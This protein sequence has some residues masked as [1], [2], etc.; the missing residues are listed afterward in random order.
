[1]DAWLKTHVAEIGPT[2]GA[3]Y[4]SGGD[5]NRL[6]RTRDAMLLMLRAIREGYQVLG[7]HEIPITPAN[8]RLFEWLPEPLLLGIMKRMIT[9]D[10]AAIKVGHA[11]DARTEMERLADEFRALAQKTSVQTPA[12][13]RLYTYLNPSVEPI[14]DG[15]AEIPV[16]W[17]GV[18][19]ALTVP[20]VLALLLLLVL[21]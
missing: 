20:T 6:A 5:R 2:A 19:M 10:A 8:H 7:E 16:K 21:R 12:M 9:S 15:S 18:W 14:A 3:L 13:D 17:S 11:L 1:M 4:M